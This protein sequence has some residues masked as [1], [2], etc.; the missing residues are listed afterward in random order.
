MIESSVV[1]RAATPDDVD[2]CIDLWCAAVAARDGVPEHPAV[3]DRA[4]SKF[5]APR[6][7]LLVADGPVGALDGFVLVTEPGTG[8]PTDPADAAYLSLLAVRPEVQAYGVGRRL[9]IE[10]VTAAHT[11]GHPAVALHVLAD[12]LRA[13]RL[14]EAAG[15]HPT[16]HEFPHAVTGV[17]TR[18][19]V[20][21]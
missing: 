1:V 5:A 6:V 15:F 2:A 18:T 10:A 17:P 14:Y 12:N 4:A 7:E 3:R 16:G 9:L 13:V 11:A 8:R 19:Y 21:R 20:T